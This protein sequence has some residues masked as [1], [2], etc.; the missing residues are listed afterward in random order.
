MSSLL[1]SVN[2]WT[3]TRYPGS[4]EVG[5]GD[6]IF[7]LH[8]STRGVELRLHTQNLRPGSGLK[9]C[10][11]VVVVVVVCVCVCA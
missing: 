4:G 3:G 9:V 10:R 5:S 6:P 2:N 8:E 7:F 1:T 11:W